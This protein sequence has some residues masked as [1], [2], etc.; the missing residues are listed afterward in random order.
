MAIKSKINQSCVEC[1]FL[2]KEMHVER[3]STPYQFSLKM[4]ERDKIKKHDFSWLRETDTLCCHFGVWD[5]GVR[6]LND[7]EK[8][9]EIVET[10]REEFCFFW[11]YRPGMLFRAAEI[12]QKRTEERRESSWERN[13]TIC[14]LWIAA[15]AL[16][17]NVIL[18]IINLIKN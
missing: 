5:E 11:R 10:N 7:E 17:I 4:L 9:K 18:E 12:L 8:Y 3:V 14:G 16:V 2:I 15:V 13:L 6:R 1:H